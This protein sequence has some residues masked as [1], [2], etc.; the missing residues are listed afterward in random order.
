[1]P[2]N[3]SW[4]GGSLTRGGSYGCICT[5]WDDDDNE[6]AVWEDGDYEYE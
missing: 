2:E 6:F 5:D 1:M 3:C 4:C